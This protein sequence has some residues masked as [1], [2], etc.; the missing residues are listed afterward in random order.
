MCGAPASALG[1]SPLV[2]P[3]VLFLFDGF[4]V[5]VFLRFFLTF[6]A[7]RCNVVDVLDKNP[8]VVVTWH[9]GMRLLALWFPR[10]RT[11]ALCTPSR[12]QVDKSYKKA[13]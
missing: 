13:Q 8:F 5:G 9:H 4:F 6:V 7:L 12:R 2:A 3:L 10:L 1:C 11:N